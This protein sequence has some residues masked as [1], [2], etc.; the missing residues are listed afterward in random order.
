[1]KS[2]A[3][4]GYAA[5]EEFEPRPNDDDSEAPLWPT[6]SER[7]EVCSWGKFLEYWETNFPHIKMRRCGADTCTDC[8]KA[9]NDLDMA[10]R[11]RAQ[12]LALLQAEVNDEDDDTVEAEV[13]DGANVE[14]GDDNLQLVSAIASVEQKLNNARLHVLQYQAQR[15]L[16]NRIISMAK[17][18]VWLNVM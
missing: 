16:V 3:K 17:C 10:T 4:S 1:M 13:V 9:V 6:G 14:A 15:S 11:T 8:L 12:R 18:D 5:K 2:L 7:K